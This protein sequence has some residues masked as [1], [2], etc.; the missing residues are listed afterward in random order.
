MSTPLTFSSPPVPLKQDA[1]VI[2]LVGMAHASSH[3]SHLLLPLVFPLFT[4]EFGLSYA[5]LAFLMT[6]FFALSGSI[7]AVSGWAVDR[8]GAL[9]VIYTSLSLFA[10]ACV[11]ASVSQGY[12]G[13]LAAAVLFGLG[14]APFHPIDFTILN[15]RVSQA[16]LGHAFSVHGLTGNLGWAVAPLF[17]VGLGGVIGWRGAYLACA[18]LFVLIALCLFA[19]RQ[20]LNT[21]IMAKAE[22][23]E[24]D[25][26]FSYLK[27]PVI[28]FCFGFFLLSTVILSVVQNF[29]V[30]LLQTLHHVSLEAAT[31]TLSAYMVCAGVGIVVGGF[32]ASQAA[33]YTDRVVACCMVVGAAML[34][35]CGSGW[36]G[37]EG[38][39]VVLALTGFAI[40]IGSPSRDLM[41]K[42]VTPKGATGRVYGLVY[43]GFDVGFA[44]A[45]LAF[46]VLMDKAWYS[47]IF[48]VV[49]LVL[50]SAM[51]VALAV[52]QRISR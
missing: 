8:W 6:I 40:G 5:E 1:Q 47:E 28:W 43:S 2:G 26:H 44:L 12:L 38:T 32:V 48:F 45:P 19:N 10:G 7:Q 31:L 9:P 29:S 16:R 46:G 34:M 27:S 20:K 22:R 41:V 18:A 14:N 33:A 15:Q 23:V 4:K 11:V 50:L 25:T 24:K 51:G 17:M 30:P 52:G 36:L 42:Q 21:Q 37:P 49:A 35:W 3:F 13:L 39:M